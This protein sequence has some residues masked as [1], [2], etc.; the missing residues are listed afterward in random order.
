[1]G[2]QMAEWDPTRLERWH[3]EAAIKD[4]DA[5]RVITRFDDSRDYDLLHENGRK[6]P[7][8]KVVGIAA[9]HLPHPGR[10]LEPNECHGGPGSKAF[11]QLLKLGYEIQ[12]KGS[13]TEGQNRRA[14]RH[15]ARMIKLAAAGHA[16]SKTDINRQ[17]QSKV[18]RTKG[19]I[20][21]KWQN[22]SAVLNERISAYLPGDLPAANYQRGEGK[23]V[24]A[25][26]EIIL[27]DAAL[28]ASLK[29]LR[30]PVEKLR[31]T[32]PEQ[33]IATEAA[34]ALV[35]PPGKREKKKRRRPHEGRNGTDWLAVNR[36]QA[37]LGSQ[38]EAF[39]KAWLED[40]EAAEVEHVSESEGDHVGYDLRA[41]LPNGDLLFVEV[42][43]TN[44]G[45]RTPFVVSRNQLAVARANPREYWVY[46]VFNLNKAP[47]L[48]RL[49]LSDEASEY[50]L[51]PASYEVSF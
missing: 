50:H 48:F 47:Q 31:S 12:A 9:R 38:G 24:E 2:L 3:V 42:K 28:V 13:W 30:A 15:Y 8:K 32:V 17:L 10:V 5:G 27:A 44:G 7:P 51:E 1:M 39:I 26:E 14:V 29:T 11:N 16:F 18:L 23:L 4:I 36:E 25:V 22:I 41:K 40:N 45:A 33:S 35:D 21:Y 19:A 46:R 49:Q 37:E 20:E 43:A 6:Y 34:P